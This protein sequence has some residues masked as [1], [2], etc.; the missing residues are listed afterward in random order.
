MVS[1]M[2]YCFNVT[3]YKTFTVFTLINYTTHY[4]L[5]S[6]LW[7]VDKKVQ[8]QIRCHTIFADANLGDARLKWINSFP[9]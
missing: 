9:N 6:F 1:R 2:C 4:S 8:I 5:A 3:G 7:D